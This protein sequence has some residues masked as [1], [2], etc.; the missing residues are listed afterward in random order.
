[1]H[2]PEET[3]AFFVEAINAHDPRRILE[4]M[5]PDGMFVDSLGE[6]FG[7]DVLL[8]AWAGYFKMVPDYAIRVEETVSRGDLVVLLG[9]AEGTYTADGVLRTE[10]R[11]RIHAAWRTEVQGGSVQTWRVYADNKPVYDLMHGRKA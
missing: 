4:M 5:T 9:T 10:N 2:S 6:A 3:A 11:F 8:D 1:M 7:T